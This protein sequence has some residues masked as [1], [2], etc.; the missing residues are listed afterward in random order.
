MAVFV[1]GATGFLGRYLVGSLL[2]QDEDVV[3]L[4]RGKDQECAK[5]RARESLAWHGRGFDALVGGRVGVC[6]G[7]LNRPGLGLSAENRGRVLE[8]CDSFLHCGA[9]VRMD[10]PLENARAVNVEGT[11]GVLEL[12]SERQRRGRLRR[13]D[14]VSTAYVA[15]RR[16]DRVA[17]EDLDPKPGHRNSY[18]RTKFEAELL[19]REAARELPITTH[20]PSIVVG[21]SNFGRTS[22]FNTLYWPIRIYVSG[23]WRTLPARRDATLDIV[24]IDFVRDAILALRSRDDTIGGTF[25]VAAGQDGAITIGEAVSIVERFFPHRKSVR[26]VDPSW[27]MRTV[28]PALRAVAFGGLRRFLRVAEAYTPYLVANPSFDTT[29]TAAILAEEG[30]EAPSIE[31][32]FERLLHYAIESDWGRRDRSRPAAAGSAPPG[33]EA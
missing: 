29:R 9:T 10:L 22:S 30:I 18:E 31:S 8:R 14:H 27:W 25:H 19:V 3:L 7:E 5:Q 17:E 1:T 33:A 12:A 21:E 28:H 4:V 6:A 32:Y 16:I 23:Y 11:R 13:V 20:R 24:P 2:E 26:Y 15:G